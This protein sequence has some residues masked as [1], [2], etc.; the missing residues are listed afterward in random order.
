MYTISGCHSYSP[1]SAPGTSFLYCLKALC[2]EKGG[3]TLMN[4]LALVRRLSRLLITA[5]AVCAMLV[6]SLGLS[7][8]ASA[9]TLTARGVHGFAVVRPQYEYVGVARS[10]TTFR[11]QTTTPPNCYGPKQIREAYEITPILNKGIT[12]KGRSIVIIDAYQSPTITHDLQT[13]DSIFGL[14]DPPFTIVAPDGL[15]P[16]D[17]NDANQ[18]S[19]AGEITL[20]V[21]WAHAI[22]PDAHIVLVLAKSNQDTDILSATRY[23]IRHNL[24]DVISQSFGEGESCVDPKLLRQEHELFLEATLKGITLFASSGDQGAAQYTCD[25][26]S[27]FLSVSSPAS[28]PLVTG[29]G[30][31]KL[32]AD[33]QTGAYQSETAWNE[34]QYE[35][36]SGGGFSTI[37]PKPFYQFGTAGIGRYRGVPDVA[38]NAA[39]DGGVL[40]VWSSSGLGQDLVF[41]F[42]GT[43]A[44]SPQWAGITALADQLGHHRVGFLNPAFYLI[45]HS[46]LYAQAFHDITTGNN[47]FTG[48]DANGNSVTIN[49][50][51]ASKGW[52]PV[53]GWGTPRVA[54][55]LPLLVAF[56]CG[57]SGRDLA[58]ARS[59]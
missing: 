24:G 7:G 22:A 48:T 26:N 45:G 1:L 46:P 54:Q 47:T 8:G 44:G 4:D 39:V 25:G 34:P 51:S 20:D 30:G 53:T 13:F 3:Q 23:A 31:T 58:R 43:S 37:Y 27:Y 21:E 29:V 57:T 11:C 2:F 36:A 41:R 49:G 40:A 9:A 33:G 19:W 12:G 18:V 50:Y 42:G 32:I 52:D 5:V 59:L 17:P 56:G 16:F 28:D 55:L 10:D 14:P 6:L 35:A 38:Y 15:T